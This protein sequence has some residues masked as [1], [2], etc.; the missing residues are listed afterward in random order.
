M[1]Y[2]KK[3]VAEIKDDVKQILENQN[4]QEGGKKA[5]YTL[6]TVSATLGGLIATVTNLLIRF[7]T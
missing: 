5:L 3:D 1:D 2:V 7:L 4:Q 6:M